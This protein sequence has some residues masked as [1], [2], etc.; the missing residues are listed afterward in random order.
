[1]K[2]GSTLCTSWE[3]DTSPKRMDI[4]LPEEEVRAGRD[5]CVRTFWGKAAAFTGLASR[6]LAAPINGGRP[7]PSQSWGIFFIELARAPLLIVG[8][9]SDPAAAEALAARLSGPT[10]GDGWALCVAT[11]RTS[12]PLPPLQS[13]EQRPLACGPSALATQHRP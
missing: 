8:G 6:R 5:I 13:A 10:L 7:N 1:M 3:S 2:G 9:T 11:W 4:F 12:E